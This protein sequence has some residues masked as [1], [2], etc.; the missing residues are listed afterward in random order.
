[1]Q[2]CYAVFGRSETLR[3][4]WTLNEH[5]RKI[6]QHFLRNESIPYQGEKQDVVVNEPILSTSVSVNIQPGAKSQLLHRD[7]M[8]WQQHH[9]DRT[10]YYTKENECCIAAL[11]P[12]VDFTEANGATRVRDIVLVLIPS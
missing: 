7:D 11:V 6:Y 10:R 4:K 5:F 8:T 1:M 9:P 12:G 2:T 3:E